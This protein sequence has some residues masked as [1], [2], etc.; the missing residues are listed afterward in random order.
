MVQDLSNISV[1][2]LP[3]GRW[4]L[5]P[6]DHLQI[7]RAMS[8]GHNL[9]VSSQMQAFLRQSWPEAHIRVVEPWWY[10]NVAP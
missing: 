6:R 9:I 2:I 7:A 10:K 4:G 3:N 8:M 5:A 1:N